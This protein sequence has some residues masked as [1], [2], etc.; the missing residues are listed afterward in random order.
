[1]AEAGRNGSVIAKEVDAPSRP[2]RHRALDA[3]FCSAFAVLSAA[4]AFDIWVGH[5][6]PALDRLF[7]PAIALASYLAAD[8]SSGFVHWMADNYGSPQTPLLGP[9]LVAP[10]R[11]HHVDPLAITRHDFLEANGDNCLTALFVLVPAY[12]WL[13]G[14]DAPWAVALELF[15]LLL[16]IG[17]LLTSVAHGWAHQER[18]PAIARLLQRAGLVVSPAHH[19]K[20]HQ[21]AHG[22][23]YCITTGWLNPLLDR[24]RFF[25]ALERGLATVGIRR[26]QGQ[27]RPRTSER[28]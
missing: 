16:A 2:L 5:E 14:V 12:V 17:V 19:A 20:H 6:R 24:T 4:L 21:G 18:P 1:M 9:K 13:P 15:V 11:E 26:S 27:T 22:T 3:A 23:H 7:F 8:F 10:F 28:T 25:R